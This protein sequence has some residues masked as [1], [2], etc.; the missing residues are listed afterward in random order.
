M[1]EKYQ[2]LANVITVLAKAYLGKESIRYKII[3]IYTR[4]D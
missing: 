3:R 2:E 1:N 4:Y